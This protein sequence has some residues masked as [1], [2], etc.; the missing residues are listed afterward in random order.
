MCSVVIGFI[1]NCLGWPAP[2]AGTIPFAGGMRPFAPI[3][4]CEPVRPRGGAPGAGIS[5]AP[6]DGSS[7]PK[8]I[9]IRLLEGFAYP[10][11]STLAATLWWTTVF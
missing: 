3:D 11:C 9:S 8:F 5:S 10:A 1:Q 6:L 4:A 7:S 2:L